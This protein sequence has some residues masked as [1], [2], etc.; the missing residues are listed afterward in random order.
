MF[1]ELKEADQN[2][3][4]EPKLA[5]LK[6]SADAVNK[7]ADEGI[8]IP[9]NNNDNNNVVSENQ[10]SEVFSV[11]AL[12]SLLGD[13]DDSYYILGI[14]E[15]GRGPVIGPMVYSG[16]VIR[17]DEHEALVACGVADSK[18]ID[19]AHRD[20]SLHEMRTRLESFADFTH[21][22][23]PDQ[24]SRDMFGTKGRTLNTLS[25]DTAIQIIV[26][27]TMALRGKLCAVFVDTV[28][29]PEAYAAKLRGRFPHLHIDV[30]SKAD[31]LFPV[32]S[33]ASIV[34]KTTRDASVRAIN[35]E[36]HQHRRDRQLKR[37]HPK[38]SD[39]TN[40]N[41]ELVEEEH[42]R[43][44]EIDA[45]CSSS[46]RSVVTTEGTLS[47]AHVPEYVGCGY[48]SDPRAM[49]YVRTRL[50][51]FFVHTR[52]DHFIRP[53]WAPV[54]ELANRED[55][56]VPVLF[57]EDA[58]RLAEMNQFSRLKKFKYEETSAVPITPEGA[59]Q[60][61]LSFSKPPPTRHR[62]FASLKMKSYV[63]SLMD[64]AA[65]GKPE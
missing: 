31:A 37:S 46:I 38:H 4:R 56:C 17:L 47:D 7:S 32:V 64:T 12:K 33:A 14:D 41:D 11:E 49:K 36:V 29:S 13:V 3:S 2:I 44:A 10:T 58:R 55:V 18:Q 45:E 35:Q 15:A 20:A 59:G 27:A 62:I 26:E 28:G 60:K 1:R 24:I 16:A 65:G 42:E 52:K 53:S 51:R 63:S 34:A 50:H 43:G 9:H 23:T 61:K 48:P 39:S 22:I 6:S 40:V 5:S 25:H 21:V 8:S 19:E 57:E 30:R 54:V